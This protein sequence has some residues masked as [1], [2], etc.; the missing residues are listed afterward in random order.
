MSKWKAAGKYAEGTI[1]AAGAI[2]A[3]TGHGL[4]HVLAA[5][6]KVRVPPKLIAK[7][8][9]M[10]MRDAGRCFEEGKREWEKG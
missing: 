2:S 5:T 10:Q 3:I 7:Y 9:E 4:V 6:F 1:K 8:C